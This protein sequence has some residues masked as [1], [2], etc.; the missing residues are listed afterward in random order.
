MGGGQ[1]AAHR[2]SAAGALA[3]WSVWGL[4]T[5]PRHLQVGQVELSP[6]GCLQLVCLPPV[7]SWGGGGQ[8]HGCPQIGC[9]ASAVKD[10]S[11]CFSWWRDGTSNKDWSWT[12]QDLDPSV[13]VLLSPRDT[14]SG[15]SPVLRRL[16]TSSGFPLLG[17]FLELLVQSPAGPGSCLHCHQ[18]QDLLDT[19][20]LQAAEEDTVLH[21]EQ[22]RPPEP[23]SSPQRVLWN[24]DPG[25]ELVCD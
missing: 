4:L 25:P 13:P 20:L 11:L 14:V 10:I 8:G 24:R 3:G 17:S 2:P 22:T 21:V 19:D 6:P 5:W 12:I 9:L 1:L 23:V 18:D 7:M 16:W 15:V